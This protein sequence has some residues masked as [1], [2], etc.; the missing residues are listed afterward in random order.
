MERVGRGSLH[1]RIKIEVMAVAFAAFAL[2]VSASAVQAAPIGPLPGTSAVDGAMVTEIFSNNFGSRSYQVFVPKKLAVNAGL[3]VVLHGCFMTGEQMASGLEANRLAN[4]RGFVVIYPEQTYRDNSWKCW[5][6]FKPENQKR[7]DGESSIIVGMV[8][9][10]V[11]KYRLS[12]EKVFVTGLSA[13]GAMTSNL[14]GCY[15]DVFAGGLVHSG[16][17]FAAA[18]SESEAH[19]VTAHGPTRDLDKSAEQALQC[20]P[21]RNR[22]LPVIVV[23]GQKDS[24]VNP[25][26][27]DRTASLFEKIN[28]EIF[29]KNGG[30]SGEI[31]HAHARITQDGFKYSAS[32]DDAVFAGKT[33]VRKVMVEGMAHAWSGGQPTAPYME[34]RGVKAMQL[35]VDAF[36]PVDGDGH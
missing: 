23:H 4:E 13:G 21:S 34:P 36:F 27:A 7:D 33:V 16:L 26:N 8:Q 14:L 12:A 10:T 3:L 29:L 19:Q 1:A 9:T 11:Q 24:A 15:S 25:I 30:S 31:A 35:L 5:N 2:T 18:Q 28:T 6:W 32:V 20:S 22:L 17:E